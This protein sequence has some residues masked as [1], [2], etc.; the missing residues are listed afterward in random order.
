CAGELGRVIEAALPH[1]SFV[2]QA[3]LNLIRRR[4]RHHERAPAPAGDLGGRENGAEVVARVAC[5]S[6]REVGVVEVEIADESAVEERCTVRRRSPSTDQGAP[7]VA[8][9]V[10]HER[11]ERSDEATVEGATRAAYRVEN[12]DLERILRALGKVAP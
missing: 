10:V 11:T 1:W 9:T 7:R 8:T 3:A 4:E 6:R 5:L 2:G 12:P